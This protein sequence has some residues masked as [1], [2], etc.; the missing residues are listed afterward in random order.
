MYIENIDKDVE[1][2]QDER[3][4]NMF[5]FRKRLMR[6]Y[7]LLFNDFYFL[8]FKIKSFEQDEQDER[9]KNM[10]KFRKRLM[11]RYIYYYLTIVNIFFV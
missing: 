1:I 5:K 11:Q 7:I 10:F 8:M 3:K 4:K 2:E 9:K 6:K